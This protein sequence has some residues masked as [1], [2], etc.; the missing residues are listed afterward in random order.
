MHIIVTD[1]FIFK[2]NFFSK[3]KRSLVVLIHVR[4]D[5]K[6]VG[7]SVR[8]IPTPLVGCQD[9]FVFFLLFAFV[10]VSLFRATPVA[11]GSSQA[12]GRIG[13]T[14]AGHSHCSEGSKPHL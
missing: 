8:N 4:K 5:F 7:Y 6:L 14:S 10:F 11:C 9:I 2:I 3:A 12:R 1:N 13:A